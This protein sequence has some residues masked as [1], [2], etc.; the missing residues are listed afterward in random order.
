MGV[1]VASPMRSLLAAA[2]DACDLGRLGDRDLRSLESVL[3]DGGRLVL[4]TA[5]DYDAVRLIWNLNF[6]AFPLAI[7]RP[8]SAAEV[9]GTIAWC[10]DR[11]ITPRVRSG[12]HSFAGYSTSGTLV[13]DL[14]DLTD[15]A[16][17]SDGTVTVGAGGLLGE[18][19]RRL[20][21][22]AGL[23]I[24]MGTCPTVGLSGLTMCG[25]LGLHMRSHGLTLDRLRAATVVLADGSVVECDE[26]READLFWAIRGGGMG[27]FGVVTSWRFDPIEAIP[28][29]RVTVAWAAEDFVEM[30]QAFQPW[31]ATLPPIGFTAAAM[32]AQANGTV[33]ARVTLIDQNDDQGDGAHL[34]TLANELIAA[35][36]ASPTN[37]PSPIAVAP[38][39]CMAEDAFSLDAGY[40][41]SRYAMTPLGADALAALRDGFLARAANSDLAGTRA[42]LLMDGG[43]GAVDAVSN[44]ATA[45]AHRGALYSAQFGALWNGVADPVSAKGASEAWLRELY[46]AVV[47]SRGGFE[48]G[49]DGG[50][51]P[52]YW[53]RD[54]A[55]WQTAY[56]GENFPRLVG[57]KAQ[58]DPDDVFRFARSIPVAGRS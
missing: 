4:P 18:V 10:R 26:S 2:G 3:T 38:P 44:T 23:T 43:G 19:A 52:G 50:C 29:S 48:D 12:G 24:P 49:F 36:A 54:I 40:R 9:A 32:S 1:G 16:F 28:Q 21:C 53:D 56:Y 20:Y 17:E 47:P 27:S 58:Y 34:M 45:F 22:D 13:V 14:R 31:L 15:I 57:V 6:Q 7:V 42:F 8:R 55:D 33:S 46:D 37:T 5:R 30:M 25:G 11:G 41:K 51:Y 39:D 35:C